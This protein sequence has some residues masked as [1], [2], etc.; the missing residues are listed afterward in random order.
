MNNNSQTPQSDPKSIEI[1][2]LPNTFK[3]RYRKRISM[4]VKGEHKEEDFYMASP[5][6]TPNS[7]YPEVTTALV[8]VPEMTQE[9]TPAIKTEKDWKIEEDANDMDS[10]TD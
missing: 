5:Q 2:N 8:P 10:E 4:T 3:D 7:P 6:Y 1:F 9:T